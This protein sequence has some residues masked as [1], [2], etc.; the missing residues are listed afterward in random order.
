[1]INVARTAG[2]RDMPP[3]GSRPPSLSNRPSDPG[4]AA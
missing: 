4:L 2:L 3:S 1:M